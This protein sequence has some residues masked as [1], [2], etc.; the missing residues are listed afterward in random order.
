MRARRLVP[1]PVEEPMNRR[2]LLRAAAVPLLTRAIGAPMFSTVERPTSRS[3]SVGVLDSMPT[4]APELP[5][6]ENAGA[7]A[8]CCACGAATRITMMN[9]ASAATN[10][11]DRRLRCPIIGSSASLC[12]P[13]TSP[14]CETVVCVE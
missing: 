1:E 6:G 4:P 8:G 13:D 11:D 7:C 5:P 10:A 12:E 2:A 14:F 3:T 9:A